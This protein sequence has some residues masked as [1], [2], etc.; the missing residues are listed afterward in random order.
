[1]I[2]LRC[3]IDNPSYFSDPYIQETDGDASGYGLA[4]LA[5]AAAF[6]NGMDPVMVWLA[7]PDENQKPDA[8]AK[9]SE[10]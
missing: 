9:L 10:T 7:Q 6:P 8:G 4:R 5:Q 3:I 2:R 1:M